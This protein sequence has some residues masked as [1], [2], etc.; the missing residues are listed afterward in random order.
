MRAPTRVLV[1][2][3]A[4]IYLA[5][6]VPG[7]A[8]GQGLAPSPSG[9]PM[10]RTA[11]GRP[12]LSGIWRAD[13]GGSYSMEDTELQALGRGVVTPELA[14]RIRSGQRN[15]RVVDPPDGRI[16]YQSWAKA[17]QQAVFDNHLR[18]GL[19]GFKKEYIDPATKVDPLGVPRSSILSQSRLV[20]TRDYVA[21][22]IEADHNYRIIPIT[23]RP[24]LSGS[25]TL[26]MGDSRA[27]WDGDSFVIVTTNQTDR[28]WFD[29][30][31][32]FHSTG[33]RVTE[34]ITPVDINTLNYEVSIEDPAVFTRP[35]SLRVTLKRNTEEGYEIWEQSYFEGERS[36]QTIMDGVDPR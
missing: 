34:R 1:A 33:M 30:V 13:P 17:Q 27:R 6:L 35:W 15:S 7:S 31:G 10:P 9:P 3:I 4:A 21:M 25:I 5:P 29:V 32:D 2:V 24:H 14:D 22:F 18:S 20:Q 16:P 11:E 8:A 23:D 19:P 36:Y 12:D 26:W 28:T